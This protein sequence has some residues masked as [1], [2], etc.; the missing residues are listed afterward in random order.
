MVR[1]YDGN[2]WLRPADS[3]RRHRVRTRTIYTWATRGQ[4]RSW[5]LSGQLWVCDGDVADMV[6]AWEE[7]VDML[8][9]ER[10]PQKDAS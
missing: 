8:V 9:T 6:L 5:K 3:A 2:V 4:V 1:D 7:R 10:Q